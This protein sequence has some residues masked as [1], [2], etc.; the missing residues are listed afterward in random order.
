VTPTFNLKNAV[1]TLV[2]ITLISVD[3]KSVTPV[4]AITM[5]ACNPACPGPAVPAGNDV[6]DV[7]VSNANSS[8]LTHAQATAQVS[9]SSKG[10]F[11]VNLLRVVANISM[12]GFSPQ[13]IAD[14]GYSPEPITV[15]ANDADGNPITGT[16]D[17]PISLAGM[18]TNIA[19]FVSDTNGKVA[20]Q[21]PN[22]VSQLHA[23][24]DPLYFY[25]TSQA[26]ASTTLTATSGKAQA[27]I[28]FSPV[29]SPIRLYDADGKSIAGTGPIPV[30]PAGSTGFYADENGYSDFAQNMKVANNSCTGTL[31]VA[32]QPT[33][34]VQ[35]G[36][37]PTLPDPYRGTY[38]I[39]K[40]SNTNAANASCKLTLTDGLGQN[41]EVDIVWN[42]SS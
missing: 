42:K 32:Q 4:S 40:Q 20:G 37:D 13:Y 38:Y 27:S 14:N 11:D 15:V 39:A 19:Y 7:T 31:T 28:A 5:I 3:G 1:G 35:P 12:T 17:T 22:L 6:F 16:F 41:Q 9:A 36:Q 10:P 26:T 8:V 24:S 33:P 18:V 30:Q 23:G 34:V 25:Y 21:Y 29:L 2:K